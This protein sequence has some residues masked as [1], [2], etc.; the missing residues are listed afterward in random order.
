MFAERGGDLDLLLRVVVSDLP[1]NLPEE[2][3]NK[4]L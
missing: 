2:K 1:R 4:C 3:G